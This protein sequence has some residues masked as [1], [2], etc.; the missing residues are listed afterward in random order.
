M[1]FDGL[2]D[3]L[4]KHCGQT[5]FNKVKRS[6]IS[7]F[8]EKFFVGQTHDKNIMEMLEAHENER[9]NYKNDWSYMEKFKIQET[10][11]L[12]TTYAEGTV[13]SDHYNEPYLYQYKHIALD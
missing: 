7:G 1:T 5:S 8:F 3:I 13:Q 6:Y 2:L 12:K 10:A 11:N 9:Q 4:A